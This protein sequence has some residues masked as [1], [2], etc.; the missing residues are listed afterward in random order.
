LLRDDDEL[1]PTPSEGASPFRSIR[2]T[3]KMMTL[4]PSPRASV[5]PVPAEQRSAGNV[6]IVPMSPSPGR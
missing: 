6:M 2:I 3:G 5:N 4:A 1:G